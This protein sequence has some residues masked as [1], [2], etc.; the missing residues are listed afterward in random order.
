LLAK[1]PHQ[2]DVVFAWHQ[3]VAYWPDAPDP[4]SVI[5]GERAIKT[6][7]VSTD[8]HPVFGRHFGT[9]EAHAI[10]DFPRQR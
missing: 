10:L 5:R 7:R 3:D 9:V 4:H 8:E 2:A 1:Q 6:H